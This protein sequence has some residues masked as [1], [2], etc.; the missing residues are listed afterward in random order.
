[1][2]EGLKSTQ[3]T[4]LPEFQYWRIPED[5]EL[6]FLVDYIKIKEPWAW[7]EVRGKNYNL[8]IYAL[9]VRNNK[10]WNIKGM[11]NPRIFSCPDS[12][13]CIDINNSI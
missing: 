8:D 1:M 3:E 4:Y 13:E 12:Y 6:I 5:E 9:L 7:I 2:R 11:I 10:K